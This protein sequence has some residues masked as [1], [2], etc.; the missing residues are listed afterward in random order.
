M[1]KKFKI[2]TNTKLIEVP[3]YSLLLVTATLTIVHFV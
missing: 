2:V 1:K 3:Y